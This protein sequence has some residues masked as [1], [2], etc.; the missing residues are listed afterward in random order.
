MAAYWGFSPNSPQ[1]IL[2]YIQSLKT[3]CYAAK[4]E[5]EGRQ[6]QRQGSPC[7]TALLLIEC[8]RVMS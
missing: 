5:G 4:I 7:H 2:R 6:E 1:E 8:G 3:R